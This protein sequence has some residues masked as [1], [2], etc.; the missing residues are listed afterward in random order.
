MS[1]SILPT[2]DSSET[3]T[4]FRITRTLHIP[5]SLSL[6]D[7]DERIF[8]TVLLKRDCLITRVVIVINRAS[9]ALFV[10]ENIFEIA[11]RNVPSRCRK[12]NLTDYYL[13]REVSSAGES[14]QRSL[15]MAVPRRIHMH[16]YTRTRCVYYICTTYRSNI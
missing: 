1:S 15:T 10:N 6:T 3:I 16:P 13:T 8:V 9:I 4:Y 14:L 7:Y 5:T 12:I 2:S 11:T